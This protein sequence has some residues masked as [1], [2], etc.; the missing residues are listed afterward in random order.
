MCDWVLML[1]WQESVLGY[2]C[3]FSD[4]LHGNLLAVGD[5]EGFVHFLDTRKLLSEATIN[6]V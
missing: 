2:D 3:K 1:F 4:G 6:S 5:E